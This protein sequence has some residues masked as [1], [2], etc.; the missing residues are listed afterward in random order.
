[1]LGLDADL[2]VMLVI[3]IAATAVLLFAA[4]LVAMLVVVG[5]EPAAHIDADWPRQRPV[6]W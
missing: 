1:M 5:R 3:G 4:L 2:A 6:E